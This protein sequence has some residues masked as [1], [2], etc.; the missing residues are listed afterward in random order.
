[1][2]ISVSTTMNDEQKAKGQLIDELIMLR[3]RVEELETL[4]MALKKTVSESKT[5]EHESKQAEHSVSEPAIFHPEANFA[6]DSEGRVIA[7]HREMERI[8]GIKAEEMLGKGNYEYA[9]P[10]YNVRRPLL[11]D[12]ILKPDEEIEKDYLCIKREGD[13]LFADSFVLLKGKPRFLRIK[14]SP[15]YDGK[16]KVTGAI[17]SIADVTE[18]RRME[19]SMRE[20]EKRYQEVV[21]N[22]NDVIY[23]IDHEGHISYISQ[24]VEQA[25]GYHPSEVVGNHC[26]D[27]IFPEDWEQ[28]KQNLQVVLG[29]HISPVEFRIYKKSGELCWVRTSSRPRYEKDRITLQGVLTDIHDRKVAEELY[30]TLAYSSQTGVYIAQ[31]SMIQFVNPYISRYS[32]YSENELIGMDVLTIVYPD[33]RELVRKSA[34]DMLKGTRSTPYEF[35]MTDINGSIHWLMGTVTAITYGGKPAILGNTIEVTGSK[36]G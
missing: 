14:A 4:T 23:I 15:L 25:F 5:N 13:V 19:E 20:S 34:I 24:V 6:I 27:Y 3:K 35:R 2:I 32:G 10:F 8:T 22:I 12:L 17:E 28:V 9:L 36:R 29:G 11:V 18:R 7:W 26:S 16:G 1:M 31:D 33:D 30:K 21:E